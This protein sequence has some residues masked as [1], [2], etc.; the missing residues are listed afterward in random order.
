MGVTKGPRC[1]SRLVCGRSRLKQPSYRT[2]LPL[3]ALV[4][5]P[6]KAAATTAHLAT[7]A[8]DCGS[9]NQSL[10]LVPPRGG[11]DVATAPSL[12]SRASVAAVSVVCSR[13][14]SLTSPTPPVPI[15]SRQSHWHSSSCKMWAAV[16]L[17]WLVAC[18]VAQAS[19]VAT[20][21]EFYC[22]TQVGDFPDW[23]SPNILPHTT[24]RY[25]NCLS[26]LRVFSMRLMA[27]SHQVLS[28]PWGR[29]GQVSLLIRCSTI[30]KA[31]STHTLASHAS[32]CIR[33]TH[34]PY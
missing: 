7:V 22:D 8:T 30:V 21:C 25:P 12:H 9:C 1:S 19:G 23:P 15:R 26:T 13:A 29:E 34:C 24:R 11:R 17:A 4:R 2:Y 20:P 16:T 33:G 3:S 31:I 14:L 18:C 6:E 32:T 27:F 10:V 5:S 28:T